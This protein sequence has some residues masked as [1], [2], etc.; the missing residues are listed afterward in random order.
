MSY[1]YP[2]GVNPHKDPN[3]VS[4]KVAGGSAIGIV[5]LAVGTLA[6]VS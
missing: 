1:L 5:L 4:L 2:A 3:T 6:W